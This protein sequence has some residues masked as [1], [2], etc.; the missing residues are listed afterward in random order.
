MRSIAS[1]LEIKENKEYEIEGDWFVRRLKVVDN[2]LMF[3]DFDGDYYIGCDMGIMNLSEEIE[4]YGIKEFV[5]NKP[6]KKQ[7]NF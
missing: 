5:V 1:C 2:I 3:Y 4:R 6:N 7:K